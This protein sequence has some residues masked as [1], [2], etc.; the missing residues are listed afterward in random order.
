MGALLYDVYVDTCFATYVVLWFA[1]MLLAQANEEWMG[2][3]GRWTRPRSTRSRVSVS[4]GAVC[5]SAR[6]PSRRARAPQG[7][8]EEP[9]M[10]T[11]WG[12]REGALWHVAHIVRYQSILMVLWSDVIAP[13]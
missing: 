9:G 8:T 13:R 3:W 11:P 5:S 2:T 7:R 6:M 1:T 4:A 10:V 12:T